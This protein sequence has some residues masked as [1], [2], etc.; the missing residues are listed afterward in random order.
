MRKYLIS[1]NWT[2]VGEDTI[3]VEAPTAEEA[4]EIASDKLCKYDYDE[5]ETTYVEEISDAEI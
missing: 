5:Y 3:V 1:Y 2:T 4:E